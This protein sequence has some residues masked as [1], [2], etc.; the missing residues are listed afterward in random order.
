MT[1]LRRYSGYGLKWLS[2]TPDL[3][4]DMAGWTKVVNEIRAATGVADV[5]IERYRTRLG[6]D[7]LVAKCLI[8]GQPMDI[9]ELRLI[10]AS[11]ASSDARPAR[12]VSVGSLDD[13]V[14]LGD[15]RPPCSTAYRMPVTDIESTVADIWA[16]VL[17]LE[18]IGLDDDVYDFGADSLF[19]VEAVVRL[20]AALARS[21][22]GT[23]PFELVV[24]GARTPAAIVAAVDEPEAHV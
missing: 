4:G 3:N 8:A 2:M 12:Y 14:I 17:S 16:E 23:D 7:L 21:Y 10:A 9:S 19:T 24:L 22:R 11:V 6:R 13:P 5:R 1:R 15:P 18:E 20:S